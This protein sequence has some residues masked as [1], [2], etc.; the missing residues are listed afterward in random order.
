MDERAKAIIS[1]IVVLVAN[2]AA[3]W[4]VSIDQGVWINGLCAIVTLAASI[5]AIWK[6][7]NFSEEAQQGQLVTNQLKNE[8]QAL[9]MRKDA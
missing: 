5:W 9:H 4:G 2:L 3:L 8:K 6:N 1:A 7:H